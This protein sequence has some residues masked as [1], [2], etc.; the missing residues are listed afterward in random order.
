M[1]SRSLRK[2]LNQLERIEA[3][4]PSKIKAEYFDIAPDGC[5]LRVGDVCG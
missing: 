4:L 1:I 3:A 5:L 2:R